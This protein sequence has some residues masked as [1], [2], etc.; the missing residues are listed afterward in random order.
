MQVFSNQIE[1]AVSENKT[2]II[3][4]DAN[5]CSDSWDSPTFLHKQVA[6]ELRD[7]L[8]QCGL[9]LIPLGTTYT[10]ARLSVEDQEITSSLDHIYLNKKTALTM[11]P[12]LLRKAQWCPSLFYLFYLFYY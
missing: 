6:D 4:G 7:T 8:T 9:T 3:L 2:V 10:A 1:K 11:C 5:L 12:S